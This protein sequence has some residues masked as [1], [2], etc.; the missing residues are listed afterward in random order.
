MKVVSDSGIIA[1]VRLTE[2]DRS[3]KFDKKAFTR[4][5]VGN[6]LQID[7]VVKCSG[8]G[9]LFRGKKGI[10]KNICKACLFLWD[11]KDFAQSGGIFAEATRNVLI[12][13]TEFLKGSESGSRV[14]ACQNRIIRDKLV[15][16]LV[17][18]IKGEFKGQKGRVT[19]VNGEEAILELSTRAKK[20]SMP[21]ADV[22]E[23][24]PEESGGCDGER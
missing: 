23:I 16:K 22:R 18:V 8:E 4:D 9:S 17:M 14:I 11:P 1:K 21:R 5:S 24:Y 3:L 19:Q 12:L 20:V 2:I 13:G 10:I 6:I 15:N 7:D